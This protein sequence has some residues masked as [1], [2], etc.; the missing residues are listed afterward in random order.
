MSFWVFLDEKTPLTQ[1]DQIQSEEMSHATFP[2]EDTNQVI[3][4]NVYLQDGEKETM[5]QTLLKRVF[6]KP[7][8]ILVMLFIR[9]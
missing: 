6:R 3:Y 4:F 8:V 5:G 1:D 2:T 7:L 9:H